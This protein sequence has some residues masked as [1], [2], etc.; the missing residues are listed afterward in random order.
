M[1]MS[2]TKPEDDDEIKQGMA[3]WVKHGISEVDPNG[4]SHY[5]VAIDDDKQ[6]AIA[7]PETNYDL[8]AGQIKD[9]YKK[10]RKKVGIY[11]GS[12]NP[13]HEGHA[14]IIY[15]ALNVFDEVEV[16]I[17]DNPEKEYKVPVSKRIEICKK[18]F[19]A[20]IVTES[21]QRIF[22]NY[23]KLPIAEFAI[24]YG[25]KYNAEVSLIRGLRSI[26]D[27]ESEKSMAYFNKGLNRAFNSNLL[28]KELETVFF[29][30]NPYLTYLSSTAIR[31]VAKLLPNKEVFNREFGFFK[32]WS[33]MVWEEYHNA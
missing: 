24:E 33:D 26:D 10:Q 23:T 4:V 18:A 12:F 13:I 15:Q 14:N 16:V 32:P 17:A 29:M 28:C 21:S 27:F 20:R 25:I 30:G 11:A 1:I 7:N 9:L 8:F 5:R 19:E 31:Q 3:M 22:F 2:E 6:L